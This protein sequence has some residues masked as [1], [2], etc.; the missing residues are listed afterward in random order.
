MIVDLNVKIINKHTKRVANLIDG[1]LNWETYEQPM[2]VWDVIYLDS[3][4]QFTMNE[5]YEY[6][7]DLLDSEA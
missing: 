5:N 1:F 4:I 2:M 6:H 3:G 7:W